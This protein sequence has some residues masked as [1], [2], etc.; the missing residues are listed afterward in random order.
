[1]TSPLKRRPLNIHPL[2]RRS[3]KRRPLNRLPLKRCPLK[4]RPLKRR[5]LQR[6][7]LNRHPFNRR[8]LKRGP[9]HLLIGSRAPIAETYKSNIS[10]AKPNRTIN[11]WNIKDWS[12]NICIFRVHWVILGAPVDPKPS[13]RAMSSRDMI[14]GTN[15]R[16][17]SKAQPNWTINSKNMKEWSYNQR[18]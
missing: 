2:K 15:R 4:R 7:P 9:L 12:Y 13:D 11:S 16:I 5:P 3:L 6:C 8:P 17:I 10:K 18:C 14:A 1:M